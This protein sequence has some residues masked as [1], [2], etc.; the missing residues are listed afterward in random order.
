MA[1]MTMMTPAGPMAGAVEVPPPSQCAG[2]KPDVG[3]GRVRFLI[4][5]EYE[6]TVRGLFRNPALAVPALPPDGKFHYA[7]ANVGIAITESSSDVYMRAAAELA[8]QA[9]ANLKTLLPCPESAGE[10]CAKQFIE[11]F[12][13]RAFRRPLAPAEVD[14]LLKVFRAGSAGRAFADGIRL[15]LQAMLGSGSFLYRVDRTE[16]TGDVRP[17]DGYALASRLSYLIWKSMPDD[18]L[19]AAAAKN[20]LGTPAQIA[21]EVERMRADPRAKEG[22]LEFFQ[23]WLGLDALARSEKDTQVF[24]PWGPA[25]KASMTAEADALLARV[26]WDGDG[27]AQTL[28]TSRDAMVD[29]TLAPLYGLSNVKGTT[30]VA[31]TLDG[32]RAGILTRAAFLAASSSETETNPVHLGLFVRE[33]VLCG[34]VPPPNIMVEPPAPS[35]AKTARER[36]A[37]HSASPACAPCHALMDPLGLAFENYDAIGRYR[38]IDSNRPI[39]ASGEL[40]A[41]GDASGSF[42]NAIEL[43]GLLARSRD[44]SACLVRQWFRYVMARD[45]R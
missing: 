44:V 31:A 35:S 18:T 24:P 15:V 26:L 14:G 37:E 4:R 28:F 21:A 11:T 10:S 5:V 43:V 13:T 29:G 20:E 22:Y 25:L 19:F 36:F 16:G 12:G 39:D 38:T 34:T 30:R 42:R 6:R 3:A 1:P 45:D 40:V 32:N 41:A 27:R 8:Q 33:R 23:R 7:T 2:A 9:V 17:L